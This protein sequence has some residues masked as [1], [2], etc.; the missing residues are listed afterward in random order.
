[1][2]FL[3]SRRI[4][5]MNLRAVLI[6]RVDG[7]FTICGC[8]FGLAA[9]INRAKYGTVGGVD[10]GGVFAAAT[11]SAAPVE[12]EDTFG[13]G[14]VKDGVGVDVGLH[15]ADGLQSLQIENRD[16]VAAAVAGESAAQVGSDG[17]AVHA[18]RVRNVADHSVGICV[19]YYGVRAV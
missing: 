3:E 7:T 18:W 16:I 11:V 19:H 15:V 12:G 9:Q 13:D 10:G 6:V 8:E 1:M 4:D 5:V 2:E 14:L 17:D